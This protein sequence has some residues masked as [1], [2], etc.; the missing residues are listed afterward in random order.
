LLKT[1]RPERVR[2]PLRFGERWPEGVA[3][4]ILAAV[5]GGILPLGMTPCGLQRDL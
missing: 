1:P 5:E 3:P 2:S 4:A